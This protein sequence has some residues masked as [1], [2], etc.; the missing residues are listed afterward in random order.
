MEQKRMTKEQFGV[1][2]MILTAQP[3][4]R[5]Y[6]GATAEATIQLEL[7]YKHVDKANPVV[8]QAVCEHAAQGDHW[9]SLSELKQTL[10]NNGGYAR[11]EQVVITSR[12]SF[13]EAPWP[14][15]ACWTYQKQHECS[16]K[17]AALAVLPV[18]LKDNAHHEDYVDAALFLEKAKTN[19]G[20]TGKTGNVRMPL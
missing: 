4:G 2:W 11:P 5:S 17:D 1:G 19:F 16:L 7:Y 3:W 14:L 10:N 8:W 15:K 13:Q 6:R 12:F 20:V 9:P 18:W